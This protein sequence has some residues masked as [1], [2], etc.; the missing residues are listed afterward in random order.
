MAINSG[1]LPVGKDLV[2][3]LWRIAI[4]H[5]KVL[6]S[7]ER[8]T[9]ITRALVVSLILGLVRSLRNAQGLLGLI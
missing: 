9:S 4:S 5:W 2:L 6:F 8:H 7:L 1:I 3:D